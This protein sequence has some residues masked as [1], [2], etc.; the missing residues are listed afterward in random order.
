MTEETKQEISAWLELLRK[1][2]IQNGVSLGATTKK[3]Y[4][5]DTATYLRT[6]EMVGFDVEFEKLVR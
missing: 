3:L 6:K 4:F 2:L 1:C 5:F